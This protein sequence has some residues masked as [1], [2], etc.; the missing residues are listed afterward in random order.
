MTSTD[1][2]VQLI[3]G[4]TVLIEYA[5]LRILV[6]P[7]FDEPGDYPIGQRTLTKTAGP[8][9]RLDELGRIDVVLL[10]HDQHPDNLDTAGRAALAEAGQVLTTPAA[11]ERLGGTATGL[12]P[13][14]GMDLD[15]PAG[16]VHVTWVP[17]IHGPDG[18]EGL[19]GP[20]TGFVLQA[21]DQPR[22]YVSGDN[23]SLRAV[24]EITHHLGPIDAAI[25]FVGAARTP[26][27]DAYLT[28]T[29]AQSAQAAGILGA[30]IVVPAHTDGWAHF[31]QDSEAVR[32]AFEDASLSG[33]LR[34]LPPGESTA[35]R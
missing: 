25:L 18:T 16:P 10:S 12:A 5:G 14:R 34:L 35:L 6:D 31:T 11:A 7:T 1:P 33:V 23:A 2:T 17:A 30:P 29:A 22:V 26:L 13:W 19:V 3:G 32:A 8:A 21:P 4:P 20:V 9:R 27:L 24:A 28:L 15:A